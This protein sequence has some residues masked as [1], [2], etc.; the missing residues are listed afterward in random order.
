MFPERVFVPAVFDIAPW[1]VPEPLPATVT[2]FE[3]VTPFVSASVAPLLTVAAPAAAPSAPDEPAVSVPAETV[4]PP[5]KVLLPVS[6]RLPAPAFVSE[7]AVAPPSAIV[8]AMVESWAPLTVS[9][10]DVAPDPRFT[11]PL[12]IIEPLADDQVWA[13]ARVNW[14]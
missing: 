6:V 10:Y 13:P 1:S 9:A 3:T 4:T 7:P 8:P 14:L 11:F 2:A 12:K 5:V